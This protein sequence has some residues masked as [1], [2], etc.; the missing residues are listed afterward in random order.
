MDL[1]IGTASGAFGFEG[2]VEPLIE[3]TRINHVAVEKDSWWAA[4][5][6]GRIHRN[7]EVAAE[8]PDGAK[9]LCIQP[10]PDTVWIGADEARLYGL[11][12]EEIAEDDFFREAPGRDDWYTPWGA[13][14]DVRSM[15]LDAGHTLYVNV[16]VG[17]IL[18]YD[19]TGVAPTLDIA[20]DAHQVSAHPSEK[21]A[22][23]AATAWGLAQS[24]NGHDFDF[25]TDG[26]HSNYCRAVAVLEDR[27]LVSASTGPR[28]SRGRLY[29][30]E[31]WEGPLHAV[32]AGLP[33]WFEDNLNTHCLVAKGD[34]V[35]AGLEDRVWRSEDRGET[36]EVLVSDLPKITCLA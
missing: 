26:L 14:A 15:T 28:T 7:G 22:V 2:T 29:A 20:A 6:K 16:H 1:L 33:E 19:N 11:E 24:H 35:H 31:L 9:P 18:R 13:P 21:E 17:G 34:V 23:F 27:V 5:G 36:W 25:R 4:D 12:K 8:M 10:T 32:A 30:G 3:G